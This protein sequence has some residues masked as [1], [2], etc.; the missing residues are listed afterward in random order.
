[1]CCLCDGKFGHRHAQYC[2]DREHYRAAFASD[3]ATWTTNL[4]G[5]GEHPHHS[6]TQYWRVEPAEIA[7]CRGLPFATYCIAV[8]H[9]GTPTEDYSVDQRDSI[10][11]KDASCHHLA[12]V[13]GAGGHACPL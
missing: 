10:R 7:V 2:R 1:R 13:P 6:A 9:D 5:A 3:R 12:R 11:R 4:R 8:I